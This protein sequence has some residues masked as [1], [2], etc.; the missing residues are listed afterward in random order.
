MF[1]HTK[2][3]N[4]NLNKRNYQVLQSICNTLENSYRIKN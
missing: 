3:L 1:L 4:I 2:N